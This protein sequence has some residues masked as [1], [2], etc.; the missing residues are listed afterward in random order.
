V[1]TPRC[2]GVR[3]SWNR[4][5]GP[6]FSPDT[7]PRVFPVH[8]AQQRRHYMQATHRAAAATASCCLR[9]RATWQAGRGV[10]QAKSERPVVCLVFLVL[11]RL[12]HT[13]AVLSQARRSIAH[14]HRLVPNHRHNH[15][16]PA[17]QPPTLFDALLLALL[18]PAKPSQTARSRP[19]RHCSG[20]QR[21][22]TEPLAADIRR[23]H[24]KPGQ[25][26][27]SSAGGT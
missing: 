16:R 1:A 14:R 4:R 3:T 26:L 7:P 25:H 18:Y 10:R 24:P 19:H 15:L 2:A 12:V 5:Y 20:S 21:A 13:R 22:H 17:A 11:S 6:L 23:G 8:H 27:K 9:T